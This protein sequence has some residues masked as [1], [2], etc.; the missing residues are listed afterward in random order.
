MIDS[1]LESG[2]LVM[3]VLQIV[4]WV[5]VVRLTLEICKFSDRSEYAGPPEC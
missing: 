3:N 1:K 5:T 2:I 4:S